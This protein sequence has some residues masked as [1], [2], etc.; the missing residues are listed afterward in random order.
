[1][2]LNDGETTTVKRS[3][4]RLVYLH[5]YYLGP[6]S[7]GGT[8][9]HEFAK[10][11]AQSGLDVQIVTSRRSPE[12]EPGWTTIERDGYVVHSV[13]VPYSNQ[14]TYAKRIWAF[15]A[16]AWLSS[17][18]A[19]RLRAD[20]LFATST[21]LTIIMPAIAAKAF[22]NT[23]LVFEVRDLWPELPIAIGALRSK[24]MI[25]LARRMESVAYHSSERIV[26]LS[27]GMRD[28]IVRTGIDG[29]R[30]DM[31]PNSADLQLFGAAHNDPNPW[32][33]SKPE[34]NDRKI[35]LYCGTLG[36]INGVGYLAEVAARARSIDPTVAFVVVGK[37]RER[38]TITK[39][40]IDLQVLNNNFYMYDPVPKRVVAQAFAASTI[41]TSLFL[42][43]PEMEANS[44]N[45]FFDGLASGR[46]VAI[47]YGGWQRDLLEENEAGIVVSPTDFEAAARAIVSLANDPD[48]ARRLGSNARRL[49]ETQF[50]RDVLAA[51]LIA[52]LQAVTERPG[53]G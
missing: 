47:N 2:D 50:D 45:K 31:I 15:L 34:L 5:Q 52:A 12:S 32:L 39:R 8:R 7:G 28:G 16:F 42:P 43:V 19:R 53:Q 35:I 44:A 33:E 38:A 49:A 23:P 4:T 24:P 41:T 13:R 48:R 29:E 22:R 30:I 40:A 25:W 11:L 27:P 37:G 20:L 18:K 46:P 26:A 21:P 6:E 9:T 17:F 3:R 36:R 10:R 51:K 14:M 1:M